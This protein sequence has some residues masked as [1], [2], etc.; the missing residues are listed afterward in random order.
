MAQDL[1]DDARLDDDGDHLHL[2]AALTQQ[3]VDLVDPADQLRPRPT[4]S[5][6]LGS[7]E[8]IVLGLIRTVEML[9]PMLQRLIVTPPPCQSGM[10]VLAVVPTR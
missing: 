8:R 2:G 3:G 9:P 7:S 4:L 1:V 10:R 5:T 6:P